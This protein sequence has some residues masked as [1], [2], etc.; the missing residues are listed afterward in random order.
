MRHG[1]LQ[2]IEEL[3][4]HDGNG[5]KAFSKA[6]LG[7]LIL[8]DRYALLAER[9]A[10]AAEGKDKERLILLSN[11]LKKVP[12]YPAENMYEAMQAFILLWQVMCLEQ[13]PNPFAFSL[14]NADR[15]FEPYRN[16]LSRDEAASLFKH[17]LVFLKVYP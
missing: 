6:L 9:K 7:V 12:R 13:A 11:T 17:F 5:Y 15:I 4:A 1:V 14:G 3:K 16:G 2:M 10:G 8:A